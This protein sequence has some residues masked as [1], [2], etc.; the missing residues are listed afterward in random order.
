MAKAWKLFGDRSDELAE[1]ESSA[2]PMS[3][4]RFRSILEKELTPAQLK[5]LKVK[6]VVNAASI[7]TVA[8]VELA[9]GTEQ[10]I[11]VLEP[12]A[13]N[14]SLSQ[15]KFGKKFIKNLEKQGIKTEEN[16]LNALMTS[17]EAQIGKEVDA[18]YEA[19]N[20]KLMKKAAAK[21]NR[22]YA[23]KMNQWKFEVPSL[24]PDYP[25]TKSVL[26]M[27]RMKGVEFNKLPDL[28]R[29]A[30]G[31]EKVKG[32]VR[33]FFEHGLWDA[34]RHVGNALYDASTHT[35]G[36]IDLAQMEKFSKSLSFLPDERSNVAEFLYAMSSK[37]EV[38]LARQASMMSKGAALSDS[39]IKALASKLK[40]VLEKSLSP[41]NQVIDTFKVLSESG[42][43]LKDKYSAGVLK[44]MITLSGVDYVPQ[45]RFA[46]IFAEEAG[47]YLK[48][49]K[50]WMLR[51]MY[52]NARLKSPGASKGDCFMQVISQVIAAPGA[53]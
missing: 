13:L 38:Y 7:K 5:T 50:S 33:L 47:K 15:F 36:L 37:D 20:L 25:A 2:K 6:S 48:Q 39:E 24:H 41:Q 28:V 16:L 45:E 23:S 19:E 1:F 4:Y 9:D 32:L 18:R 51:S 8:T 43:I 40:T 46:E 42:V 52:R 26:V 14:Q 30:A 3:K 44:G 22:D 49:K 35:I 17:M 34:D 11:A 31:E 10:I 21:L 12:D 29:A 53:K 27:D